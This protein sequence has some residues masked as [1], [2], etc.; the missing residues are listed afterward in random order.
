MEERRTREQIRRDTAIGFVVGM[1]LG[2]LIDLYTGDLGLVTIAGMIA[3]SLVG[4]YGS[5][6][7][8]WMEYPPGVLS[9]IIL[10]GALFI[11]ALFG[12]LTALERGTTDALQAILPFAPL[13]PGILLILAIGYA[14]STLDELQRRIQVEAMAIGFG[15]TALVAMT[16]GLLGIRGTPQPSGMLLLVVMTASWLAGKL[17]TRWKYR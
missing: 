6:R 7:I 14:L 2:G 16:Y 3:G 11:V 12:S 10:A 4:Y 13:V 5:R 15:I 8:H 17:W 1:M 9:R